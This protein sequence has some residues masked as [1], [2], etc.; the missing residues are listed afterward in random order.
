MRSMSDDR[1]DLLCLDLPKAEALRAQR[2]GD[3]AARLLADRAKA[4][5]D[6]T[7]LIIADA[8]AATD[9]LCVCDL[10]WVAEKPENLVSHHL[11]TL[12]NAGLV[13]SRRE[14]KMVMYAVTDGGRALLAAVG[15][16]A[17][18]SA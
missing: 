5:A 7:R 13:S 18:V 3:D 10:A 17:G 15:S 11:R 16:G 6:S 9:E 12:R 2:L 1:C 14:G 4:L 8:L